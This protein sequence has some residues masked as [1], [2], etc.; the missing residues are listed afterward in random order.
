MLELS[1]VEDV[2]WLRAVAQHHERPDGSGY[3]YGLHA[4]NEMAE[5]VRR[6][7]VYT[8]M[9]S[10]RR[11]RRP[12][13]ADTASRAMYARDPGHPMTDALVKEFGIYPPGCAVTLES[14]ECGV[15]LRRGPTVLTPLVAVRISDSGPSLSEFEL[16]D[17]SRAEHAIAG[18]AQRDIDLAR[19]PVARLLALADGH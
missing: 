12:L 8:T 6:A 2:D 19:I 1:G 14:G 3:P 9:L 18:M 11:G 10:P 13:P 17:T 15:V 7:D 4:A 5:L 16:R